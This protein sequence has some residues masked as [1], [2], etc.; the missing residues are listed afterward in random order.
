ME[1]VLGEKSEAY[2]NMFFWL[3]IFGFFV[4][5]AYV[6][7]VVSGGVLFNKIEAVF[8]FFKEGLL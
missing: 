4:F 7:D 1:V 8:I 3:L 5:L 2:V 6:F